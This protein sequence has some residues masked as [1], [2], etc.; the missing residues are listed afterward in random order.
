MTTEDGGLA[1]SRSD[2]SVTVAPLAK[3]AGVIETVPPIDF[4]PIT[5]VESKLT[6]SVPGL[7]VTLVVA[8]VSPGADAVTFAVI[9][10]V[11]RCVD[12]SKL[13]DVWPSAT[14]TVAGICND[15]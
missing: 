2:L 3:K 14:N 8:E 7:M 13:A 6:F 4:P 10:A 11:T 15:D 12:A 9:G 5:E 1:E